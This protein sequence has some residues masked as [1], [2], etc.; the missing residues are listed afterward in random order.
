MQ[1]IH[2]ETEHNMF[3]ESFRAF[4]QKEVVPHQGRLGRGRRG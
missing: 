2:F 4:L 3:R 1:R